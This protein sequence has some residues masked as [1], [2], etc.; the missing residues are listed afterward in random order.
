MTD[1]MHFDDLTKINVP[2]GLLDTWTKD[3]LCRHDGGWQMFSLCGEWVEWDPSFSDS[4]TYRA[5]PTPVVETVKLYFGPLTV[6]ALRT[7]CRKDTHRITLTIRDG[8]PD[9]VAMVEPLT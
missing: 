8:I 1:K 4:V 3:R 5:K 7:P 6:G 2:F 9:P